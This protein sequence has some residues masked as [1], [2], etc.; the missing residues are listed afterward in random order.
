MIPMSDLKLGQVIE[1][2]HPKN[3]SPTLESIF[4]PLDGKVKADN[5]HLEPPFN[6]WVVYR[7]G[8]RR[9]TLRSFFSTE[10]YEA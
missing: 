8:G 7:F 4:G 5:T 1:A 3:F 9:A 2:T 10:D 6:Y